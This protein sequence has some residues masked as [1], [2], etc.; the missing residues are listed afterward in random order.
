MSVLGWL[1][2]CSIRRSREPGF[3]R[4]S[5]PGTNPSK[6]PE[7][8]GSRLSLLSLSLLTAISAVML[9]FAPALAT[10][11][12][13]TA[14][15]CTSASGTPSSPDA[16]I[17][18]ARAAI[19]A[20]ITRSEGPALAFTAT[21][22]AGRPARTATGPRAAMAPA[23]SSRQ[24]SMATG[25]HPPGEHAASFARVFPGMI[26]GD[27]AP[28]RGNP[29]EPRL[30]SLFLSS[31]ESPRHASAG[32]LIDP[33]DRRRPAISEPSGSALPDSAQSNGNGRT[34]PQASPVL[35]LV[36]PSLRI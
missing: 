20:T 36:V 9:T 1:Q 18:K 26:L 8:S 2:V 21:R 24:E 11:V 7:V 31:Q 6:A 29:R 22:S 30:F 35:P 28:P 34:L 4:M 3:M 23:A 5:S 13:L 15:F 33:L 10:L 19:H 16:P 32:V 14:L 25:T 27:R 17:L 12:A